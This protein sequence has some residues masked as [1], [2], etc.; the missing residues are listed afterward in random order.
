MF[1]VSVPLNKVEECQAWCD[2]FDLF[3]VQVKDEDI[4]DKYASLLEYNE[5][6][7]QEK[8]TNFVIPETLY[9]DGDFRII[10]E[11]S[12]N[13]KTMKFFIFTFN[14]EHPEKKKIVPILT[15]DW[16]ETQS[17]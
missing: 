13:H 6:E 17:F 9:V 12:K 3:C 5:N 15:M 11:G 16:D 10:I 1:K 2:F 4:L 7:L 8:F 14:R